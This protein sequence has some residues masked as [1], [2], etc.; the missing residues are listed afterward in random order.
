[1]ATKTELLKIIE[2]FE[3]EHKEI[4]EKESLTYIKTIENLE[5]SLKDSNNTKNYYNKKI[6]DTEKCLED[7]HVVLDGIGGVI[8]RT[9]GHETGYSTEERK[10]SIVSRLASAIQVL[11]S[12][13]T[14]E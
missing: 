7:V 1:M 5:K 9:Y 13:S 4:L 2:N 12:P 8:P 11:L 3:K 14:R 10:I 6:I